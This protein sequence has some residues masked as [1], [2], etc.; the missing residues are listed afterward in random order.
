M[1][2]CIYLGLIKCS[3]VETNMLSFVEVCQPKLNNIPS[4]SDR[5][6]IN[7]IGFVV[8]P[9]VSFDFIVEPFFSSLLPLTSINSI[10]GKTP[11][12]L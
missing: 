8:Q 12:Q 6:S 9:P 7:V 5:S 1:I 11:K 10:N 3:N 4:I 2:V